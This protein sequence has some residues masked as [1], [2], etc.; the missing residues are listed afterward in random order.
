MN[1]RHYRISFFVICAL[2]C[3]GCSSASSNKHESISKTVESSATSDS[4]E[5]TQQTSREG[6]VNNNE[7]KKT[8][9]EK[10][11]WV[12]AYLEKLV[13]FTPK[14]SVRKVFLPRTVANMLVARR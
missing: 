3:V 7:V 1:R 5:K 2:F 8:P 4:T 13:S 9:V 6:L 14:T 11:T 12:S 10:S